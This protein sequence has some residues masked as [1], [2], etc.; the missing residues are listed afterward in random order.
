MD[1][2]S[3]TLVNEVREGDVCIIANTEENLSTSLWK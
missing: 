3:C 2:I 1:T